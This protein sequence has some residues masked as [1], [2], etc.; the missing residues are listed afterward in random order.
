LVRGGEEMG[1]H[2]YCGGGGFLNFLYSLFC[3]P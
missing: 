3:K 1:V 2:F